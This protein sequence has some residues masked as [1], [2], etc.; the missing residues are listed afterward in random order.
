MRYL[1]VGSSLRGL[2]DAASRAHD[3]GGDVVLFDLEHPGAPSGLEADATVLPRTWDASFLDGI[4]RVITSPWFAESQ[5]PLSD[6]I[7]RGI[8]VVTEAGFGLERLTIPFAAVT[9]TNGKTTVTEVT[10]AMLRASGIDALAAGNIG[11]PVSALRDDDAEVL[12]LELSSYQL[13]F[14]GPLAPRACALLNIAEDHLDWHGSMEAYADAKALIFATAPHDAVLAYNAD[15]AIVTTLARRATCRTVPCSGSRLPEGGNGVDGDTV[16]IGGDRYRAPHVDDT[17]RFNLVV[18]GTIAAAMG[19]HTEGIGEV[20]ARFHPGPHRREL[21]ATIGGVA[22]VNDSK[23]TNPHA[24]LAAVAAFPSVIL[25]A[26][27]RNKGLDLTP[28]ACASPV[29]ALIPFGESG[30]VIADRAP[31]VVAVASGLEEAFERAVAIAE[32]GD[33]VLLSPGCASF[34]EFRSYEARG[35]AFRALVER[36]GGSAA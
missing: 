30:P 36:L 34:D 28:L 1:V 14:M 5:P 18:A 16:V 2:A 35:A 8:D 17:Y 9:G 13:R 29:K 7:A 21:V 33:T 26:G 19:G 24:A 22:Y 4:D 32:P 3:E 31:G 11:T 27:G 23:A 6:A 15:D 10:T 12:V 25:L 20:I